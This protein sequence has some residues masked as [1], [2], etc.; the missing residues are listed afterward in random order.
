MMQMHVNRGATDLVPVPIEK[1]GDS[2]GA[3]QIQTMIGA[4]TN[5]MEFA[6]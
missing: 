5:A 2:Q 3:G 6:R 4:S 1:S